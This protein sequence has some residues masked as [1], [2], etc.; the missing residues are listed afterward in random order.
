MLR[1][2]GALT[3]LLI[4]GPAWAQQACDTRANVMNHL[5][6]K[7][8]ET[9][10]GVGVANNGGLVEIMTTQNGSTWTM[11]MTMPNGMTCL[12]AAGEK[13]EDAPQVV[14]APGE[15]KMERGPASH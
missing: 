12:M 8:S 1:I 3:V 10:V 13:W 6:Q 11:T 15:T 9:Q 7:Y 2:V 4:A 14:S 5:G